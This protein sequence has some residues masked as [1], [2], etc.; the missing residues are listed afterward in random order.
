MLLEKKESTVKDNELYSILTLGLNIGLR[1]N[2]IS[3][4]LVAHLKED[5]RDIYMTVSQKIKNSTIRRNCYIL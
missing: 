2:E 3:E 5:N 4:L 1:F